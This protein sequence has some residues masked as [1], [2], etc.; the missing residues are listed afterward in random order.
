MFYTYTQNNSGGYFITNDNVAEYVIIEANSI[1]EANNKAEEIGIYFDGCSFGRD[2]SC[3]GDRWCS[4]YDESEKPE[5]YGDSIEKRIEDTLNKKIFFCKNIIIYYS[6]GRK[7]SINFVKK[8]KS[9]IDVI[10]DNGKEI[11]L[12]DLKI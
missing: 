1:D 8:D 3:C 4:P 2:C 12:K 5:I 7:V 9:Y 6:S 10:K 11:E